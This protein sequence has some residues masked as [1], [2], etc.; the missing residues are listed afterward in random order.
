MVIYGLNYYLT[1]LQGWEFT[2]L[3]SKRIARFCPKISEWANKS[4]KWAIH[5]LA[6]FLWASWAIRSWSLICLGQ[7]ERFAHGRSFPLS[8]LSNLLTVAHLSWAIWA[9]RSQPL[10]WLEQNER[11]SKWALSEWANSQP[12]K[13]AIFSYISRIVQKIQFYSC[14]KQHFSLYITENSWWTF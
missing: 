10:I 3:I 9:N 13:I 7:P 8:N 4:K 11:M 5:L 14:Y 12:C 2:H 1:K 6:H